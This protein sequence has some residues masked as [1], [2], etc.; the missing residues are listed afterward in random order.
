MLKVLFLCLS[1]LCGCLCRW[2]Y[3]LA[4]RLHLLYLISS[5]E[6]VK[7]VEVLKAK[8]HFLKRNRTLLDLLNPL[9]LANELIANV[10]TFFVSD[11]YVS[12]FVFSPKKYKTV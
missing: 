5:L 4:T 1:G 8:K 6:A 12:L 7:R 11:Q 3:K 2:T 10:T 9:E